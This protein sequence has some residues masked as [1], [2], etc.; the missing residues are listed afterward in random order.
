[1]EAN[2]GVDFEAERITNY[3][4]NTTLQDPEKRTY[5]EAIQKLN[6]PFSKYEQ[7]LWSAMLKSKWRMGCIDAGLALKDPNN[8]TRRKLFTMLAILEASP[9]YTNYFLPKKFSFLYIFKL[10][11][12][13]TR[14][15]IRAFLG[16]IMVSNI[17][18][19]C[20]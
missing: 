17:Q 4:L 12:V 19:K 3:L 20:S 11:V 1:M 6:I 14:A 13:G 5:S 2:T 9:N 8:N 15:V 7:A 16:L 18:R 10:T